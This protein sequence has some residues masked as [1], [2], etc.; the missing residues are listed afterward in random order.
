MDIMREGMAFAGLFAVYE[1][2]SP[3]PSSSQMV[4]K[5]V[6]QFELTRTGVTRTGPK[7][8]DSK[9]HNANVTIRDSDGAIVSHHREVSGNMTEAERAL[10]FPQNTLAT[11]T[12]ARAL[13][14]ALKPGQSMTITGQN[15]PCPTCKGRMNK[16]ARESGGTIT[17]QWRQGGKTFQWNANSQNK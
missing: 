12:E 3:A 13:K 11:H 7:G 15:P 1:T 4:P 9:H 16:A 10:G 17:Y 6:D 5:P 8:V 14:T 2:S